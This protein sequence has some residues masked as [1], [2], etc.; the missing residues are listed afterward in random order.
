MTPSRSLSDDTAASSIAHWGTKTCARTSVVRPRP[1]WAP[2]KNSMML[3]ACSSVDSRCESCVA[4]S[5][6]LS[7]RICGASHLPKLVA[8]M[9]RGSQALK[10]LVTEAVNVTLGLPMGGRRWG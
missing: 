3:R 4:S 8:D 10:G 1:I 9:C 5:G 7:M 6:A 2:I